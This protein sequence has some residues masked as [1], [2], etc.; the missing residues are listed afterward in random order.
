MAA[1]LFG[2]EWYAPEGNR[3]WMPKRA[4]LRMAA[5][6]AAGQ[7]LYL[8]G[9]Y[10]P[11]QLGAGP[12]TVAVTVNGAPLAPATLASGGDFELAFSLP[13]SLAGRSALEIIVE[14][15]RTFRAGA[16]IRD[17]GLAFGEF[18]VR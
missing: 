1:S 18:E 16:D 7:K 12:L 14:V 15:S 11:E 9:Y 5:P 2:P 3:R 17:L 6:T 13:D 4:S 10:P 8:R